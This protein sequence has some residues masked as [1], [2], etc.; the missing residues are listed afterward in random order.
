MKK[1]LLLFTLT[2]ITSNVFAQEE[3][4]IKTAKVNFGIKV[5]YN[6]VQIK[7]VTASSDNVQKKAGV[8][9][10]IFINI[11]TS[12]VFSIQPE[13]IYSSSE[14]AGRDKMSLLHIPV[15]FSFKLTNNFTGFF[16]PEAQF[17]LSLGNAPNK[18]LF[19]T[20][21]FGF[22]FGVNYK[23]TPNI[24]IEARPYFAFNKF[25]EDSSGFRKFNILQ[26]GL[27]YKF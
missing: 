19:N 27:V 2:F 15:L 22:T 17:L 10:G 23:I 21:L 26:L 3:N 9:A 16:G 8:Y 12:D 20:F 14:F 13:V 1:I 11:P 5:G 6:S 24:Y 18:D 4:D 7:A 25:L